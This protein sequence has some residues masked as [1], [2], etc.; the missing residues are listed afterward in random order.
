MRRRALVQQKD[1][2]TQHHSMLFYKMEGLGQMDLL[3]YSVLHFNEKDISFAM[4]NLLIP[5]LCT[6]LRVCGWTS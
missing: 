5:G 1:S 2:I 6:E 4:P 3:Q